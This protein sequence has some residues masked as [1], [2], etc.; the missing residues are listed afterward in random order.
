MTD[1]QPIASAPRDGTE[2][3]LWV[4]YQEL[5][6]GVRI[7]DCRTFGSTNGQH[8]WRMRSD[9]HG[10]APLE[11]GTPSHWMPLP[12]PPQDKIEEPS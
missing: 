11:Y 8:G 5:G 9:G 2:V 4:S 7:T 10:T 12:P 6:Y 1:W 3:D